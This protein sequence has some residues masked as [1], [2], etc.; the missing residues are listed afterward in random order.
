MNGLSGGS[1]AGQ[2]GGDHVRIPRF[3]IEDSPQLA[4][5]M[6]DFEEAERRA[7]EAIAEVGPAEDIP[8]LRHEAKQEIEIQQQLTQAAGES[9][10]AIISISCLASCRSRGMSSAGSTSSR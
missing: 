7:K 2:S 9:A 5:K 3:L 1:M 8:R 10:E 4:K 6:R